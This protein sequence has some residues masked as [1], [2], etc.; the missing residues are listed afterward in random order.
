MA[1]LAL[2]YGSSQPI[3]VDVSTTIAIEK[4]RLV[5]EKSHFTSGDSQLELNGRLQNFSAPVLTAEYGLKVNLSQAGG[6][7]DLKSRQSGWLEATGSASF[8][9]RTDYAIQAVAKAYN[10]DYRGDGMALRNVRAQAKIDAGPTSVTINDLVANALGGQLTAKAEIRD[11]DRFRLNGVIRHLEMRQAAA[12][13][14]TPSLPY[15]GF[16]SGKI[17]AEGRFSE[18]KRHQFTATARLDIGPAGKGAP[19]KGLIDAKYNGARDLLDLGQSYVALPH[20]RLDFQGALGGQLNIH[21]A[22]SDLDDVLPVLQSAAQKGEA[23][24]Q[25]PVTVSAQGQV[26]FD[27]TVTGKLANPVLAGNLSGSNFAVQ[28]QTV[29]SVSAVVNAAQDHLTVTGGSLRQKAVT[30]SFS[31]TVGLRDWKPADDQPVSASLGL[32]NASLSELLALA[33]RKDVPVSGTLN[34]GLKIGGVFGN[35]QATADF[36]LTRGA[37]LGEPIDHLTAHLEAPSRTQQTLTAQLIDG[38]NQVNMNASYDHAAANLFPGTLTFHAVSNDVVMAKLST[39]HQREPD[40]QGTTR[41]KADGTA[42]ITRDAAGNMAFALS[43][44]DADVS[45]H[46]LQVAAKK[47]GDLELTANTVSAGPVPSVEVKLRSNLADAT[48]T[49]DGRWALGGDYSGSGKLQFS[50]VHLDTVRRVLLTPEQAQIVR[51]AGTVE[52]T[53]DVSGPLARPEQLRAS[54]DI[55]K[56]EVIPLPDQNGGAAPVDLTVRNAGPIHVT[57]ANR[58]VTVDNARIV[59]KESEFSISGHVALVPPEELALRLQGNI[60]LALLHLFNSDVVSSGAVVADASVRGTFANP[61][62]AGTVQLKNA[63]LAIADVPNGLSNANG[64]IE[65][66]G[67]QAT[68]R[69]LTAESGGGKVKASGFASLAGGVPTYRLRADATGVRVRYP[70]GVSTVADAVL[71]LVGT[72]ARST[73]SGNVTIDRLAFNPRTDLGSILASAS[74]P[75]ETPSTSTGFTSNLQLDVQIQ[76]SPDITFESSYTQSVEADANLRLRGTLSSPALLGRVNIT[77]G[78]LTFFGNNYT[79]NQGSISFFNP[80]KVEP[81]LNIDLETV[82]RGVDVT[83]TVSGP[84]TKLN[85]SYRSDP[86]LQFSDIVALLATGRTPDDAT[87]AARQPTAPSQ[88]WQQMGASALVGQAIANPAAARLQRFFGVSRLKIDP[89]ISGA[90]GNPQAKVTLEQQ[91]TPDI[92]F[93]YITDVANAQEQVIRVEWDFSQHWSAVAMRDENGEFGI[94]FLYKKRF[95]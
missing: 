82:A 47:L 75:P 11:F 41:V 40:V 91:V 57:M 12:L 56:L 15:D 36:T 34:A 64:V 66:Y 9:S 19:M 28:G 53:L 81:V 89:T 10:V 20:T 79:I 25:I 55:P 42:A 13:A 24:P 74:A 31:G 21:F 94:D 87:I 80:V 23:P 62:F 50:N 52:G 29:D 77:Q 18:L 44:V 46:G 84:I 68:I 51:V 54:L 27:G 60:N 39:L 38:P 58:V 33:G 32:R 14:T 86:P 7:L 26:T 61:Q 92:T 3:A 69:E 59:A 83:L 30:A 71:T 48:I 95:R 8:K 2:A 37:A 70:Q 72:P 35:P 17:F 49:A 73:L 90:T 65:F 4:N 76:T 63:N 1:P 22:S 88:S 16:V 5:V 85:V 78:E 45:A 6:L 93:T 43:S 67:N